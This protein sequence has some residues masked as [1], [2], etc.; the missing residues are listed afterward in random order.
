MSYRVYIYIWQENNMFIIDNNICVCLIKIFSCQRICN[1]KK[2]DWN[3]F[4][5]P[6]FS[7][8][9]PRISI[10]QIL[11]AHRHGIKRVILPERNL[12]DLVEVPASVLS[13]LEVFFPTYLK[14]TL[15]SLQFFLSVS[16]LTCNLN[17]VL[18]AHKFW[19]LLGDPGNFFRTRIWMTAKNDLSAC[20]S[21]NIFFH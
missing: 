3:C 4:Y 13:N 17:L 2:I 12:K 10:V 20:I 9:F 6:L 11:A 18:F 7:T 8:F 14:Q 16:I 15:I 5:F 19:Q 21:D 1:N